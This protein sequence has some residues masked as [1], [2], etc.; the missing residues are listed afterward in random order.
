[1]FL[2]ECSACD[3]RM[4]RS[5]HGVRNLRNLAP[6]VIGLEFL[7]YL[8]GSPAILMT[9]RTIDGLTIDGPTPPPSSELDE[10]NR[11]DG[12]NALTEELEPVA[13]DPVS[14]APDGWR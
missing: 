5:I 12:S 1:M 9:G 10:R 11:P 2:V 8:C 13:D 3:S 7:C 6:G 4:L 14:T